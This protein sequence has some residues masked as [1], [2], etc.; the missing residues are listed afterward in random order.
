METIISKQDT[1]SIFGLTRREWNEQSKKYFAEGWTVRSTEYESGNAVGAFDPSSGIGLS[2]QPFFSNDHEPPGS[3]IIGNYFPIGSFPPMT[4]QTK[5]EMEVAAQKD[6]GSAYRVRL[7][8]VKLEQ[9]ETIT[10]ILT[11]A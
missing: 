4:D 7:E 9:L 2:I 11:K 5:K 10:L 8:H 3:V 1:D 6:L